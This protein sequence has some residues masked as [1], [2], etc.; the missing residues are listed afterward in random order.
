MA[1]TYRNTTNQFPSQEGTARFYSGEQV[2]L[3]ASKLDPVALATAEALGAA[4][5]RRDSRELT[6]PDFDDY[7]YTRTEEDPSSS[8][9]GIVIDPASRF[10]PATPET[11]PPE[12]HFDPTNLRDI[13][14]AAAHLNRWRKD[15]Q[16]VPRAA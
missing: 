3:H 6:A 16:N 10:R 9:G 15:E 11:A 1:T 2:D 4:A 13:L 7:D 5:H 14:T 12:R 8:I